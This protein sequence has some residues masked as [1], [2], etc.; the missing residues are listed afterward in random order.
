[1]NHNISIYSRLNPKLLVLVGD[2]SYTQSKMDLGLYYW[3]NM[4]NKS[5]AK[6]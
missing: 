2:L 5:L 4:S 1:M 6:V 3:A